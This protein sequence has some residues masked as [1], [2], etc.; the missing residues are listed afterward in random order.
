MLTTPRYA[1]GTE[2]LVGYTK[3]CYAVMQEQPGSLHWH[4]APS[5]RLL[6]GAARH[7]HT[8]AAHLNPSSTLRTNHNFYQFGSK[9][10]Y[11]RTAEQA[12]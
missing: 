10:T 8:Y 5:S 12:P 7:M 2:Q 6:L 3:Q 11:H 4:S 9:S 1:V